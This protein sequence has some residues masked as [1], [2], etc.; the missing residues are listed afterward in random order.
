[1]PDQPAKPAD[2]P[3]NMMLAVLTGPAWLIRKWEADYGNQ[4]RSNGTLFLCD[5]QK[6]VEIDLDDP[7]AP[8]LR[9]NITVST[10]GK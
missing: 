6:D 9:V 2:P 4:L 7:A 1:M 10:K 3:S 5:L 8:G